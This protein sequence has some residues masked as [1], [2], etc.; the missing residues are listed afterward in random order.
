MP[1]F[2]LGPRCSAYCT[3][4]VVDYS[5]KVQRVRKEKTNIGVVSPVD[6]PSYSWGHVDWT[7]VSWVYAHA[8]HV[9]TN[10]KYWKGH[11]KKYFYKCVRL[12]VRVLFR[13][14]R[15][16]LSKPCFLAKKFWCLC[17]FQSEWKTCRLL[18]IKI[19]AVRVS[20][21]ST[22][23]KYALETKLRGN[24]VGLCA[25]PDA[26]LLRYYEFK[27]KGSSRHKKEN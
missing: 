3:E 4:S 18:V 27:L 7:R 17:S 15:G 24:S 2:I 9:F 16:P 26:V 5:K 21:F 14:L 25:N 8:R 12:W 22:W 11:A 23:C 10:R 13:N 19:H 1:L 20:E 6:N